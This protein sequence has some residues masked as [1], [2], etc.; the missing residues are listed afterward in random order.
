MIEMVLGSSNLKVNALLKRCEIVQVMN[1][2][3]S[4]ALS[5]SSL[6]NASMP[7]LDISGCKR[8]EME[9]AYFW[10]D[11]LPIRCPYISKWHL[12][13]F[14]IIQSELRKVNIRYLIEVLCSKS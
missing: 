2:R 11:R 5:E 3:P 9:Q 13:R 7:C 14:V 4:N 1:W 8:W 10:H 12:R 6:I